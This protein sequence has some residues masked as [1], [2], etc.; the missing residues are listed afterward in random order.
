MIYLTNSNNG[1]SF[2][3]SLL[4]EANV[5]PELMELPN[6]IASLMS[7]SSDQIKDM[8]DLQQHIQHISNT[9]IKFSPTVIHYI[10]NLIFDQFPGIEHCV[11]EIVSNAL[12]AHARA[13]HFDK[14]I[15]LNIKGNKLILDDE[16]DGMGWS[17]LLS[18][19]VPGCS[20]NAKAIFD[21]SEGI[22]QVTGRFGQ[23]ALAIFSL[24]YALPSD[25]RCVPRFFEEDGI[26]KLEL[27][28]YVGEGKQVHKIIIDPETI[29]ELPQQTSLQSGQRKISIHT[30]RQGENPLKMKFIAI[31]DK[32][33]LKNIT[34]KPKD[35]KGTTFKISCPLIK[36]SQGKLI[37]YLSKAF[38]HVSI[39][40]FINQALI[41]SSNHK[42]LQV[43]GGAL[44]YTPQDYTLQDKNSNE[45][46]TL[47]VR[48]G[49]KLIAEF[50]LEKG[51]VPKEMNV[52]FDQLPLT[53]DRLTLDF[54]DVKSRAILEAII[55]K[56]WTSDISL[57]EK[58]ALLNGLF[59][60]IGKNQYN[61]IKKI[62]D[63]ISRDK[64]PFLPDSPDF[65][66]LNENQGLYF[67]PRYFSSLPYPTFFEGD[68]YKL[69][70]LPTTSSKP[71]AAI[72]CDGQYHIFL[73]EQLFSKDL[74]QLQYNLSLL[75]KW[76]QNKDEK[77][78]ID[79]NK[80]LQ[81]LKLPQSK[82]SLDQCINQMES[83]EI[84]SNQF[85]LDWKKYEMLPDKVP[86][87]E[88]LNFM[89]RYLHP[90]DLKMQQG[91]YGY[92]LQACCDP[93]LLGKSD[94]MLAQNTLMSIS[95][96]DIDYFNKYVSVKERE[97]LEALKDIFSR[98]HHEHSIKLIACFIDIAQSCSD[99]F[100]KFFLKKGMNT[101]SAIYHYLEEDESLIL[102]QCF[103]AFT[104]FY[105]LS[106]GMSEDA[107]N[108]LFNLYDGH[109][110][111]GLF[112]EDIDGHFILQKEPLEKI[113]EN[114]IEFRKIMELASIDSL[115][116]LAPKA[117]ALSHRFYCCLRTCLND[118]SPMVFSQ[119]RKLISAHPQSIQI[120]LLL[121]FGKKEICHLDWLSTLSTESLESFFSVFISKN[122]DWCSGGEDRHFNENDYQNI[123]LI[124]QK[125]H[126]S[127][128]VKQLFVKLYMIAIEERNFIAHS[129]INTQSFT[130][131][132]LSVIDEEDIVDLKEMEDLYSDLKDFRRNTG[133]MFHN[134]YSITI[135]I[136]KFAKA[137]LQQPI[138]EFVA[139][140]E[141]M[142]HQP[143]KN[144]S[145]KQAVQICNNIAQFKRQK[146]ANALSELYRDIWEK[147]EFLS[148]R[149][150]PY[151]YA[152]L[153]QE[154]K[155]FISENFPFP[156]PSDPGKNIYLHEDEAVLKELYPNEDGQ[157]VTPLASKKE[158][159]EYAK[160]RIQSALKQTVSENFFLI[161][162][163]L[164]KQ[165]G[166]RSN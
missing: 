26:Q 69:Y 30:H 98:Y 39:P 120:K 93:R 122:I 6:F 73:N 83:V 139:H 148:S 64:I 133:D 156:I 159:Q 123:L 134:F 151:V 62:R 70:V 150:R 110:I 14:P 104:S 20:S 85:A 114:F 166:S 88:T 118:Y 21:L 15:S 10:N 164:Q 61:L 95:Q 161:R 13:N 54:K 53:H 23:G 7:L 44:Y 77:V 19:F 67:N 33:F 58:G 52:N 143:P 100:L 112:E 128:Q 108:D 32:V 103:L 113:L 142:G 29:A 8:K 72:S 68:G 160:R 137:Q 4:A 56:I 55:D 135:E 31:G 165:P 90:Q 5:N 109:A 105:S 2:Y 79:V 131:F 115:E 1:N 28:Y 102:E 27:T 101:V 96:Q 81:Q 145:L 60:I 126:L 138:D 71:V 36:E 99:P 154:T 162:R 37:S 119:F 141:K 22:P 158:Q 149:T 42:T 84:F 87:I 50:V 124:S 152:M 144:F 18:F 41:N 78:V 9:K 121:A 16:G 38:K 17:S 82:E 47:I 74:R 48:E 63:L 76:L 146:N 153:S 51:L 45:G 35:K 116:K 65:R 34:E 107:R 127:L 117:E 43:D 40:F 155:N 66:A 11:R 140:F 129:A 46:G 106:L 80:I 49:G 3:P 132:L 125:D 94:L 57:P 75:N 163:I 59:P 147:G 86:T 25:T 130:Q 89:A 24:I 136:N 97:T 111:A 91:A 12:D 157:K 92:L